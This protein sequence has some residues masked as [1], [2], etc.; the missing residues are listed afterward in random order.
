MLF[1]LMVTLNTHHKDFT[2]LERLL[3]VSTPLCTHTKGSLVFGMFHTSVI[4]VVAEDSF[5]GWLHTPL[6]MISDHWKLFK[7]LV[8]LRS[9]TL[10]TRGWEVI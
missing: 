10:E 2:T 7:L 6:K 3:K 8:D 4:F 1:T 9:S 5:V